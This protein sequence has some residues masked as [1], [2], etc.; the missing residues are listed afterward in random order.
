MF[1][2]YPK[3][4]HPVLLGKF[5]W[6]P[7]S[8]KRLKAFRTLPCQEPF[9]YLRNNKIEIKI[10]IKN[11][12]IKTGL[13]ELNVNDAE[14]A[15]EIVKDQVKIRDFDTDK[16]QGGGKTKQGAQLPPQSTPVSSPS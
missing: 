2:R 3:Y 15:K 10:P 4:I 7:P 1:I 13:L 12:I 14:T 6:R 11:K 5:S 8:G 16:G 9:C